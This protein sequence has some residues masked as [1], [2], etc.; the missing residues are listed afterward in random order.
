M[1]L[2]VTLTDSGDLKE[3]LIYAAVAGLFGAIVGE[4]VTTRGRSGDW[5]GFE[6][7][8]WKDAR[9]WYDLGSIAAIPIGVLAGCIAALT[10]APETQAVENGVVTKT[11]ETEAVL[12]TA[13]IA[14]LA[15]AAFLRVLQDRF[16]AIAK[17]Q[18]LRGVVQ[19]TAETLAQS[20]ASQV[21]PADAVDKVKD[22][23]S[24][25]EATAVVAE[26]S[27]AAGQASAATVEGARQALLAAVSE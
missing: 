4:L 25:A 23:T 12:A 20:G 2:A 18:E 16:I 7:P 19:A 21:A 13:L 1:V 9:R 10:L 11:I 27:A 5:G 6:R 17:T 14:G 22:A 15:G 8:R 3:V 24:D 26:I